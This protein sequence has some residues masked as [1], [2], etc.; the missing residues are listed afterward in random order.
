MTENDSSGGKHSPEDDDGGWTRVPAKGRRGGRAGRSRPLVATIGPESDAR[1]TGDLKPAT[2]IADEYR[3]VRTQWETTDACQTL[4]RLISGIATPP[5]LAISKAV[6]L[7]IGTFDPPDG[8][9]DT[10]RRTF[11]QLIAFLLMVESLEARLGTTIECTFQEPV[12]T[13]PDKAFIASLGHAVVES[14]QGFDMV[15]R[16]AL[17]FGVHL[18]RPIYA[19]ALSRSL[20][21]IFIG[22]DLDVWDT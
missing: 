15:T 18:Y 16:D 14:P 9:W 22:T 10:K 20:P 6:C 21:A 17:L 3:R 12:F 11:V 4:R 7:G 1:R 19:E 13:E 2:E 5:A 8:G